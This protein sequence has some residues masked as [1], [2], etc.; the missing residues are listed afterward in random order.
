MFVCVR[1]RA[2]LSI[3]LCPG[4]LGLRAREFSQGHNSTGSAREGRRG[5]EWMAGR[6]GEDVLEGKKETRL[7]K[8]EKSVVEVLKPLKQ[9]CTKMYCCK[10]PHPNK[11][12]Y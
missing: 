7:R 4:C 11:E 8:S 12:L 9:E 1:F 3:G 6:A 2:S 5:E 10:I